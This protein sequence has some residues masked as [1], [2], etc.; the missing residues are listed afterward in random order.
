MVYRVD[1]GAHV[2]EAIVTVHGRVIRGDGPL[3]RYIGHPVGELASDAHRAG[4]T[5]TVHA[6]EPPAGQ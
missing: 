5:V 3:R 6:D 4:W 2:V 1:T